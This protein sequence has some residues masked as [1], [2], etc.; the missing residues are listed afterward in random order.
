M[1]SATLPTP[2][3]TLLRT[4]HMSRN[5]SQGNPLRS[6]VDCHRTPRRPP[7]C[8]ALKLFWPW[9]CALQCRGIRHWHGRLLCSRRHVSKGIC[10]TSSSNIVGSTSSEMMR[11][12]RTP[13]CKLSVRTVISKP[14]TTV[15]MQVPA[16]APGVVQVKGFPA[17]TC[18]FFF[19]TTYDSCFVSARNPQDI[20]QPS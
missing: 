1:P 10:K 9:Q 4:W 11:S 13:Q 12:L 15:N 8:C 2:A 14:S 16:E 6:P 17:S 18:R 7:S 20:C 5:L 3:A 19:L